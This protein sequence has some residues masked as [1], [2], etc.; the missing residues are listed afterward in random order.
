MGLG[1]RLRRRRRRMG[2]GP[3]LRRRRRRTV[4]SRRCQMIVVCAPDSYKES[5]T[6]PEA[7]QAMADGV[8]DAVPDAVVI[9]LPMSDGGEGFVAAIAAATGDTLSLIHISEPTRLGM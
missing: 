2:L 6:A 5:M 1:P 9:Q 4:W 7:A 8:R 3:R